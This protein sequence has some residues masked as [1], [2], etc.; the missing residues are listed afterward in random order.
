MEGCRVLGLLGRVYT[1]LTLK[2]LYNYSKNKFGLF[3]LFFFK[4]PVHK[5]Q[6]KLTELKGCWKEAKGTLGESY[7]MNI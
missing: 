4:G 3:C 5:D 7:L 1:V 6:E 2:C